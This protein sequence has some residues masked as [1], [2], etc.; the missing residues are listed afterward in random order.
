MKKKI[1][2]DMRAELC[3]GAPYYFTPYG[4]IV[5]FSTVKIFE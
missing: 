4:A 5:F 3:N 2:K 1:N